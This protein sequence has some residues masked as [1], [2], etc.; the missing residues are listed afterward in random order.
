MGR[1]LRDGAGSILVVASLILLFAGVW[2]LRGHDYVASVLLV[3]SGLSVL[4]AAT[5]L[6]RPSLGE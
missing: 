4:R 1:L 3:L 5:E 2:Q 6:L